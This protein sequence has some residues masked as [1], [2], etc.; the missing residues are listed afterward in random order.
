MLSVRCDL[1]G[2]LPHAVGHRCTR[3]RLGIAA[4]AAFSAALGWS[5][6]AAAAASVGGG[7][8]GVYANVNALLAP[9]SVGALP[10]VSLPPEGGGPFTE[11]ALSA[12]LAGLAPVQ[13]AKVSTQGNS[14]VRWAKSSAT[15]L[16]TSIAGV[17]T[18]SAARSSCAVTSDGAQGSAAVVDLVVAGIPV[19]AVDVGPNTSITLPVGSVLLNEQRRTGDSQIVVNAARVKLNATVVTGEVVL[20]QSRCEVNASTRSRARTRAKRLRA[21]STGRS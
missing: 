19:S 9:V 17:V 13:V 14:G 4:V 15:V 11:S 10:A 20:A 1:R 2:R 8:F 12:N 3:R 21:R 7:A 5:G 6:Q 16:D 18:V